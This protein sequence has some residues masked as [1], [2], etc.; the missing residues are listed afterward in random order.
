MFVGIQK[1]IVQ[2]VHEISG[3]YVSWERRVVVT[4]LKSKSASQIEEADLPKIIINQEFFFR[5]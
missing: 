2:G 5:Y 4:K 1:Y 3:A